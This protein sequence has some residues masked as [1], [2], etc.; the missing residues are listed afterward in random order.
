M[1][2]GVGLRIGRRGLRNNSCAAFL[3]ATTSVFGLFPVADAQASAV[4]DALNSRVDVVPNLVNFHISGFEPG[5]IVTVTMKNAGAFQV[6]ANAYFLAAPNTGILATSPNVPMI[7]DTFLAAGA[8]ITSP[9]AA[10]QP[11]LT[12]LW[13]RARKGGSGGQFIATY[14]CVSASS[15][16]D[17]LDSQA[18][19]GAVVG[20]NQSAGA[21]SDTVTDIVN[22]SLNGSDAP[23]SANANGFFVSSA[24]LGTWLESRR[25]ALAGNDSHALAGTGP[26]GRPG[27]QDRW[28]A[29]MR[30]RGTHFDGKGSSFD[31]HVVDVLGGVY[32]NLTSDMLLGAFAGYG[33]TDFDT[34]T[35]GTKGRF[36]ADGYHFGVYGGARLGPDMVL[37]MLA[38]YTGSDYD[39]TSGG[40][41]GSFD[42]DRITVAAHVTGRY[43]KKNVTIEPG[44]GLT[45]AT[46]WQDGYTDSAGRS[47]AAVNI[48]AGRLSAGPKFIFPGA[49]YAR[50]FLPWISAKA[51][52]DFSDMAFVSRSGLPNL[53]N[54]GSFRLSGGVDG[55]FENGIGLSLRGDL[56][57]IGTG[58]YT[59][60]GGEVRVDVPLGD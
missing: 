26:P 45:L 56:S 37:D 35:N 12:L 9:P 7:T 55:H 2:R 24:G 21:M 52:Y 57:G 17:N 19:V 30:V 47:H 3:L 42:A 13:L 48:T 27:K 28:H 46:E 49:L 16:S 44:I 43:I 50:N 60:Y 31:G 33:N 6:R 53:K 25:M 23:P 11:G 22:G 36:E 34:V 59:A 14:N 51:E 39:N 20:M 18:R 15:E 5:D 41:K 58:K 8:S 29:W 32:K 40:T 1:G 10:A 54:V 38:A 4:C